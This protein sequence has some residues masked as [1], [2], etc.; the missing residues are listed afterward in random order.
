MRN[1]SIIIKAVRI[2]ALA[3]AA[4]FVISACTREEFDTNVIEEGKPVEA[5]M[6]FSTND[7]AETIVTKSNSYS[8]LTSLLLFIFNSDGSKC[9]QIVETGDGSLDLSGSTVVSQGIQYTAKFSTTTGTK[10][11]CA[12][13]NYISDNNWEHYDMTGGGGDDFNPDDQNRW[14]DFSKYVDELRR[15]ALDEGMSSAELGRSLFFLE[16]GFSEYGNTPTFDDQQMIMTG[17]DVI[18]IDENGNV[19]GSLNSDGNLYLERC[20]ADI[21]FN[22]QQEYKKSNGNTIT[23]NASNYYVYNIPGGTRLAPGRGIEENANESYREFYF[24]GTRKPIS[25][26]EGNVY[27]FQFFMPENIQ[28]TLTT[29]DFIVTDNSGYQLREKW[30]PDGTDQAKPTHKLWENAPLNATYVVIEGQYT[31][32]DSNNELVYTGNVS[33]T[34]HLGNF[35]PG[36]WGN[37]TVERNHRYIYTVTVKGVDNI[38]VEAK[39]DEENQPGA[40]G[41]IISTSGT[42]RT[43]SLDAHFEQVLLEY[44]LSE[45]AS[46]ALET[47]KSNTGLSD[48]EAISEHL[49][50]SIETPFQDG[51]RELRPY[52][53]FMKYYTEN[54]DYATALQKAKAEDLDKLDYKWVEFW[55]QTADGTNLESYPG[56]PSWKSPYGRD[57]KDNSH[58]LLDVYEACVKMGQV[59]EK[60]MNAPDNPD[61]TYYESGRD[62]SGIRGES[63]EDDRG[64][65]VF[66]SWTGNSYTYYAR[67][68]GF[69]DEYYYTSNPVTGAN[70]SWGSFANVPQRRMLISMDVQTSADGNSSLSNVH[71]NISQRSM[72]TFYNTN[73]TGLNAFGLETYNETPLSR[74]GTPKANGTSDTDGRSNQW[75]MIGSGNRDYDWNY[76]IYASDNGHKSNVTGIRKLTN[77]YR[78]GENNNNIVRA[79]YACMSR[80]RDLDGDGR[81]DNDEVRWYLPAINEYLRIGMGSISMSNES[82]LYIGDKS[83]MRRGSDTNGDGWPDNDNWYPENYFGDG[84]L[85]HTSTDG[86]ETFWA[87]EKGAYG[88][89]TNGDIPIRCIRHLPADPDNDTPADPMYDLYRIANG[90]YLLDFRDKFDN[91]M[92]RPTRTNSQLNEHDEDDLQNRF[93]DGLVISGTAQSGT[94]RLNAILNIDNNKTNPCAEYYEGSE[95][96]PVSGKGRWRVPNL[97]ELTI[98]ASNPAVLLNGSP[99]YVY[100]STRFSNEKVRVA[101]RYDG[102]QISCL[103][104]E[105]ER[106]DGNHWVNYR[107]VRDATDQD[108]AE[109]KAVN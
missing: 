22:I 21:Q 66:R 48:A 83:E 73:A 68:T 76:Y 107:C 45:I 36:N 100:S 70:I 42:T 78:E 92:Y 52:S 67:F 7:I 35:G 11:I 19:T 85:Y 25:S 50:V 86:K 57:S 9:E 98:M 37:F 43:Y 6:T 59:V 60:I 2:S 93:Y 102:T 13:G 94:A 30:N 16:R 71:T 106:V 81:I 63:A 72:Q 96:D 75:S 84:A 64:I 33:Y 4:I 80:N 39:T 47:Q 40:E 89:T 49:I 99:D 104:D 26:A 55:P 28:E 18:T 105:G 56:L 8:Q 34:I 32:M 38:A 44:N 108:F 41:S 20:I 77:A 82:N 88:A 103:G 23:F 10:R 101:F 61:I 17:A 79:Y 109:A 90:S 69:V 31:E 14:G 29:D 27:S 58:Y 62:P 46:A 1:K 15:E 54:K 95:N 91:N 87:V 3:A 24:D 51:L 12:L 65:T 53:T 74:Y 5:T 97:A